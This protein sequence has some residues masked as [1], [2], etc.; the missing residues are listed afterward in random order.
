MSVPIG[1]GEGWAMP[2]GGS[3]KFH[4]FSKGIALCGK[5]MF[6]GECECDYSSGAMGVDDCK[7]CYKTRQKL[8]NLEEK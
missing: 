7:Q 3:K 2:N 6:F 5:W 4:F 8:K 1:K